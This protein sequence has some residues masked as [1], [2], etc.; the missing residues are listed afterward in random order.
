MNIS[1]LKNNAKNVLKNSYWMSVL[2]SFIL[3]IVMGGSLGG[4]VSSNKISN[5]DEVKQY[6]KEFQS[7][8]SA[9]ILGVFLLV[10]F[11]IL[12][13]LLLGLAITTFITNPVRVG[14]SSFY[15][16]ASNNDVNFNH[17]ADGFSKNYKSTTKTMFFYSLYLSLWSLLFV[18]PGIIKE[19]E[20]FMIEYILAENPSIDTKRAFEISK[21]TTDGEKM[22]LFVLNLSFIGWYILGTLVCCVGMYLVNPYLYAARTQAYKY[23]K[24]KALAN[25]Y[26]SSADFGGYSTSINLDKF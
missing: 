14:H 4:S 22:N 10:S 3:S 24:Q 9:E 25:G 18:I 16:N 1:E 26:A 23:L 7:M 20:Y 19:Y 2:A 11:V 6:F 15:I 21:K 13:C 8:S 17:I 5:S 12:F